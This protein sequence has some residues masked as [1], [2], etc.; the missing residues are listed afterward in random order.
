MRSHHDL[1]LRCLGGRTLR[2]VAERRG[3]CGSLCWAGRLLLS[4]VSPETPGSGGPHI[5]SSSACT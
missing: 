3:E 1:G 5:Y 2:S 4:N